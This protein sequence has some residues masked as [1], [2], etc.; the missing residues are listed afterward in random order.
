MRVLY[1]CADRG[2]HRGGTKGASLHVEAFTAALAARGHDVT[3]VASAQH[4]SGSCTGGIDVVHERYSLGHVA[5][6]ELAARLRVPFVLEV[7]APLVQEAAR[8]RPGTV[9]PSDTEAERR[10]LRQADLVLA[11]SEPLRRWAAGVRGGEAGTTVL[12]NGCDPARFPRPAPVT[13]RPTLVFLGHPK[14]WHGADRLV[15]VLGA[16]RASGVDA[17]LLVL[18]GGP[19]A[20]AVRADAAR[21][22]LGA[23]VEVT[24]PLSPAEAAARLRRGW[25]GLAPYPRQEPFYFS[26]LK[27]LDYL[28]AGLPVVTT[29]QGDLAQLVGRAGIVV[30]PGD[31]AAFGTAVASLARHPQR[32]RDL[33]RL[34]RARVLSSCT[35]DDAAAAWE[36]RVA[37]LTARSVV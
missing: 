9:R 31:D 7:N 3:F 29:R 32:C 30:D 33:G 17:R 24:G 12:A 6:L 1:L 25:I 20:D 34:G 22:A 35:W 37:A 14:P 36:R 26:P 19:G 8:H 21:A 13:G 4:A 27:V 18:G 15:P 11:V 23:Q 10:L 2:I 16:V 5:G 28:A